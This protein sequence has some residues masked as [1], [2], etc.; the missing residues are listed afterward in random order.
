[1]RNH[2]RAIGCLVLM[3]L[4]FCLAQQTKITRTQLR[5]G[6]QAPDFTL[7]SDQWDNVQLGSFHGK[8]NVVLVFYVLAFSP[9]WTKELQA[10]QADRPKLDANDTVVLGISIDSPYANRE[11]AKQIGVTFP[12][13][14][15]MKTKV[16]A[17]YGILMRARQPDSYGY[18]FA[19][20]TT[21]V[22]DKSGAIQHIEEGDGAVDP[23]RAVAACTR[24][25]NKPW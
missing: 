25:K 10:Y 15:D 8:K 6:D 21:F 20:R 11:F 4:S 5:V 13:L 9:N 17:D 3:H 1:M 24:L 23:F 18:S 22:V 14:S 16:M 12:L 7:L 2:G 19:Q